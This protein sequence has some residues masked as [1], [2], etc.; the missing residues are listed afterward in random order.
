MIVRS[1]SVECY[2]VRFCSSEKKLEFVAGAI[3]CGVQEQLSELLWAVSG[4]LASNTLPLINVCGSGRLMLSIT[5]VYTCYFA[6][7]GVCTCLYVLNNA[8]CK[9][10]RVCTC[11]FYTRCSTPVEVDALLTRY[12][13]EGLTRCWRVDG[14]LRGYRIALLRVWVQYFDALSG[15]AVQKLVNCIILWTGYCSLDKFF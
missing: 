1:V 13:V 2:V 15:H 9:F 12:E 11:D 10:T 6:V 3:D 7:V 8:C 5:R 14:L 4:R